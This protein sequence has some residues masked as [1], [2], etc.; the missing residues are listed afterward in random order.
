MICSDFII[1]NRKV[2]IKHSEIIEISGGIFAGRSYT[3][4]Y[5][6]TENEKIGISPHLKNYN[7]LLKIILTNVTKEVYMKLLSKVEKNSIIKTKKNK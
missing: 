1:N 6:Q 3:P 7:E 4:L 2:K 5:I